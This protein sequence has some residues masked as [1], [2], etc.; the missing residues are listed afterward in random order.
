MAKD[1]TIT[2]RVNDD[3]SIAGLNSDAQKLGKSLD[4]TNRSTQTADRNIKGVARTSS[5]ASKNFSKMQQGMGGLVGAYAA[6][7]AQVFAIGAAFRFLQQAGDLMVLQQGQVAYAVSTGIALK[8]LTERIVNA[9]D[10]QI[11]FSDAA[12]AAAIGTAAGL[13]ATQLQSLGKAAKDVSIVLGRDV[14]D[15]FNRLIRGVTKAE[16]E[17]LDELGIILRL[18]D[19]TTRYAATLGKSKEDLTTYQRSQAVVADVLEQTNRKFSEVV[20]IINPATNSFNKFAKVFDDLVITVQKFLYAGLAPVADFLAKNPFGSLLLLAPLLKSFFSFAGAGFEALGIKALGSVDAMIKSLDQ[21]KKKAQIDQTTFKMLSGDRGTTREFIKGVGEDLV[22]L[23]KKSN[24]TFTGM[25]N[26][27]KGVN[28]SLRTVRQNIKHATEGTNKFANVS[29]DVRNRYVALFKEIEF[30][31]VASQGGVVS[32][33]Q[34]IKLSLVNGFNSVKVAALSAFTAIAKG[35]IQAGAAVLKFGTRILSL[36]GI[37]SFIPEMMRSMF[38]M[39]LPGDLAADAKELAE[40][41]TDLNKEQEKFIR[42]QSKLIEARGGAVEG[43]TVETVAAIAE[44]SKATSIFEDTLALD[45]FN[46]IDSSRFKYEE[47][48]FIPQDIKLYQELQKRVSLVQRSI[49][50]L[51]VLGISGGQ[52]YHDVLREVNGLLQMGKPITDE[53]IKRY[54][55][56]KSQLEETASAAGEYLRIQKDIREQLGKGF[57]NL[58]L[59][60][61]FEDVIDILKEEVVLIDKLDEGNIKINKALQHRNKE[62]RRI[63]DLLVEEEARLLRIQLMQTSMGAVQARA[64]M[65]LTKREKARF[66]VQQQIFAENQKVVNAQGE[67]DNIVQRTIESGGKLTR[68]DKE[69]LSLLEAQKASA[70]EMTDILAKQEE[71]AFKL[72]EAFRTGLESGMESGIADLI[73]GREKSFKDAFLKMGQSALEAV[74]KQISG[75][76]TD[77]ILGLIPGFKTKEQKEAERYQKIF[78]DGADTFGRAVQI[79][80]DGSLQR[81]EAGAKARAA[82]RKAAG[83]LAEVAPEDVAA[84]GLGDRPSTGDF[85]DRAVYEIQKAIEY[86]KSEASASFELMKNAWAEI[87]NYWNTTLDS[88]S[89]YFGTIW[90]NITLGWNGI[91]VVWESITATLSGVVDKFAS[92]F[93]GGN[94]QDP[95]GGGMSGGQPDP[96]QRQREQD[97]RRATGGAGYFGVSNT[98][99][100]MMDGQTPNTAFFVQHQAGGL[101]GGAASSAFSAQTVSLDSS[102][103]SRREKRR[104]R[105]AE[106]RV[107]QTNTD[108]ANALNAGA[109]DIK[110]SGKLFTKASAD[111][112][113]SAGVQD[114]AAG[115]MKGAGVS[116][117]MAAAQM[118]ISSITSSIGFAASGGVFSDGKKRS[119]GPGGIASGPSSGYPVML[120]GTE[121][122]VPLPDGKTIPVQMSGGGGETN[123][124]VVNVNMET[125]ESTTEGKQGRDISETGKLVASAV[126]AELQRQ[127]RPGGILSPYGSS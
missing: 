68:G 95:L 19:A 18:D 83:P 6:F 5:N 30:G 96:I 114:M 71:F 75:F 67:I 20:D 37:V 2:V 4:Q 41:L 66:S 99:P 28:M 87:T 65:G 47:N 115:D 111:N 121:A 81:I 86:F 80:V 72:G 110:A 118:M 112:V 89:N 124:I 42:I 97:A 1:V 120:H 98:L 63:L 14:T 17:L 16:P 92:F 23:G 38:G 107:N 116:M 51:N 70:I 26:L 113:L 123:N 15:S 117:L 122:V 64:S 35:T 126:Q 77:K 44:L 32:L 76:L 8:T 69:R 90:D 100:G 56:A 39:K 119:Y 49:S 3:G 91:T 12:Q 43:Y 62:H 57:S 25:V 33:G 93:G 29:V 7:A 106:E 125:G 46:K 79:A 108:S 9:T 21:V 59:K 54:A 58:G 61:Q 127:K 101:S 74:N 105:Q 53:L 22:D 36:V 94:T 52:E 45:T 60:S 82:E 34:R 13:T 103:M 88:F 31:M 24:T 10:A 11:K 104:Q 27:T 109:K 85:F 55:A 73:S 78:Q 50:E 84:T 102:S 40:L 48:K